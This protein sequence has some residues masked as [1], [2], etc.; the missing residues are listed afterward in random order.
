VDVSVYLWDPYEADEVE[1]EVEDE[2]EEVEPR[3]MWDEDEIAELRAELDERQEELGL[4]IDFILQVKVTDE[5]SRRGVKHYFQW[6]GISFAGRQGPLVK[7]YK[8]YGTRMTGFVNGRS[9]FELVRTLGFDADGRLA[10]V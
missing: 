4:P 3:S 10:Y 6:D 2:D 1:D 8:N 5:M 7:E 9:D